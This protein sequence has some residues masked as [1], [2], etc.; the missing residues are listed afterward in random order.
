MDHPCG[1]EHYRSNDFLMISSITISRDNPIVKGIIA[2]FVEID[3]N[4]DWLDINTGAKADEEVVN[5]INIPDNLRPNLTSF[6][7]EFDTR[8]HLFSFEVYGSNG[9]LSAGAVQKFFENALV[10]L[11]IIERHGHGEV[12]IVADSQEIDQL[13]DFDRLSSITITIE[14]PNSDVGADDMEKDVL[15]E[16][17]AEGASRLERKSYAAP[18]NSLDPSERTRMLAKVAARN[19]AVTTHGQIGNTT[20]DKSTSDIPLREGTQYDPDATSEHQAFEKAVL[21]LKDRYRRDE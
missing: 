14:R 4:L 16:M 17:E 2:H 5:E 18:G 12:N 20:K 19:G 13:F 1:A 9:R 21:L 10:R 3:K 8:I 7:F 11:P 6:H 15:A